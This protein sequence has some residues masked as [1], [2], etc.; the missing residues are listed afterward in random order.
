MSDHW[1]R[2]IW[3]VALSA[4]WGFGA[5]AP[6]GAALSGAYVYESQGRRD[7]FVPLVRNGRILGR[8]TAA[9]ALSLLK[10]VLYGILWAPDGK[11]IAIINDQEVNVGDTV[12]SFQVERILP[13][14]VIL[15]REG[16]ESVVLGLTFEAEGS[17]DTS[18]P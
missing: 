2:A 9:E 11:S 13:E 8:V 6:I 14:S 5:M 7:P 10:P 15:T 16:G 4:V 1:F 12:G 3:I 17:E 18:A